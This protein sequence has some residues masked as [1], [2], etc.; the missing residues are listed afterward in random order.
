MRIT[1][2]VQC[3]RPE[4]EAI[5]KEVK[6]LADNFAMQNEVKIHNL[7]L[8]GVF[9]FKLGKQ[10]FSS[11]FFFYP[12]LFPLTWRI[13]RNRDV[14]HIYTYLG[15]IPYLHVL[16]LQRTI[17]T[18]AAS[19]F[20]EK[21]KRRLPLLKKLK[22]IVVESE[23]QRQELLAL[24]VEEKKMSLIYPPVDLE[25]FKYIKARGPFTIL[26]ASCP[27]RREDF[28]KRGINLILKIARQTGAQFHLA[29]R[30]GAWDE[31]Q[32][33]IQAI[34]NL[35]ATNAIIKDM[36]QVYA[37]AHATIIPY[38][39]YDDFLKLMPNSAL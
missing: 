28:E 20:L 37:Q 15:D 39:H 36:N 24:G 10:F 1:Y 2:Y 27:T 3:Y 31:I 34:P 32:K 5:S 26:Y 35:T 8:D 22:L 21:V 4:F 23:K 30:K 11:H 13:S 16:D 25:K 6:L 38:T 7:H 12:L 18:A 19:C 9:N 17:L 29:W 33:R 14:N